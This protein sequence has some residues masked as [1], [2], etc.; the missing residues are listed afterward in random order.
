MT[1]ETK[2]SEF[3]DRLSYVIDKSNDTKK[4]F[5]KKCG[6]SEPQLY[7]YL[8]GNQ[9]PGT[10]FYQKLKEHY[11]FINLDWLISGHGSPTINQKEDNNIVP[12]DPAVGLVIEVENELSIKLNENQRQ[13][14]VAVLRRELDRRL[15]DQKTDIAYLVSSF[16]KGDSSGR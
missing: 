11:P 15:S 9:L 16:A 10:D 1:N 3:S 4:V 12:M 14:V 13:A 8:K 2:I 6:K 5:V 7:A